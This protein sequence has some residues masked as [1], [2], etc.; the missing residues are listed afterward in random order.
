[1]GMLVRVLAMV[2][3]LAAAFVPH[4]HSAPKID[5]SNDRIK[6]DLSVPYKKL[7]VLVPKD[8]SKTKNNITVGC[9]TLDRDYA[10]YEAYKEYLAPL[11]IKKI[12]LQGGWAKT[13]REKGVYDFSWL[14]KII[15][16]ARSRGL[17]VWLQTSYGNTVYKGGGT[18]FL[19]GGMPSSPEGK[20]AW[21]RW[22]E[23]RAKRYAG[24]VEWEM[25]NEPDINRKTKKSETIDMNVRTMEIIRKY[26]PGAKVAGL[27]LA[28]TNPVW[29]EEY[30]SMLSKEGKLDD[31]TWISYHGYNIRPEESYRDVEE[32]G[33]ILKKY[34]GKVLLRQGENGAPSEG[35]LGGAMSKFP[36]TELTQAKWNLRRM[37]GDW[38]R[39]I[40][41]SVFSISD[42]HYL[43]SDSIKI[44]NVKGLLGTDKNHKVIRIKKA[45][46][47]VQ[48]LASVFDI[49][50]VQTGPGTAATDA[51]LILSNFGYVDSETKMPSWTVWICDATP[52]NA[53]APVFAD[54][55][56]AGGAKIK[57]PV[58]VDILSGGVYEIPESDAERD[59]SDLK[60][61][62]LP[63]YDSPIIVTDKSLVDFRE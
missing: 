5:A 35:Y 27:V 4:S 13:E 41:T 40:E 29:F 32:M 37:L 43:P 45:Y 38:G 33:K 59:G 50:D 61:K 60:I 52:T 49:L 14:D 48:N 12:R 18:P 36:W 28:F 7:G 3:A 55:R 46:Y 9:E 63:V 10:D 62:K 30:V 56:F 47:A 15:D 17:T 16:D 39:G 58:W 6:T 2:S 51:D 1:M 44:V 25:W 53:N 19:K 8:V 23:E 26:D 24:K 31:F 22:V 21:N 34:S 54:Y 57:N 11:G 42:M 20:A